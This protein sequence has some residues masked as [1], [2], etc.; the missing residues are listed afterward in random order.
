MCSK[1]CKSKGGLTKHIGDVSGSA[2]GSNTTPLDKDTM[3]SI[4]ETIKQ[5]I[6]DEKLYGDEVESSVKN[7]TATEALFKQVE[8]LYLKFCKNQN[9]DKLLKSFYGLMLKST[10]LLDFEDSHI[11]NLVMIHIPGHL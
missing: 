5:N 3:N 1:I 2:E 11:T 10:T 6:I 7:V 9:Q 4:V 8:P